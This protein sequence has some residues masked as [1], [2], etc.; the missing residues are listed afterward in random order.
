MSIK[1][2]AEFRVQ[3]TPIDQ[4]YNHF[5]WVERGWMAP[6]S[7]AVENAQSRF[8]NHL[9]QEAV[10]ETGHS[11]LRVRRERGSACTNSCFRAATGLHE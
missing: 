1:G 10:K 6:S 9:K 5:Q 11:R 4:T 8:A 7:Q 2:R 3:K